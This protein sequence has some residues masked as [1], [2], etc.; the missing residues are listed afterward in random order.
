MK[1]GMHIMKYLNHIHLHQM[2]DYL[3]Q[4]G[5]NN[6]LNKVPEYLITSSGYQNWRKAN[7]PS[8]EEL[9]QQSILSQSMKHRPLFSIL[10]PACNTDLH[11]LKQMAESVLKQSYDHWELCIA[12]GSLKPSK[13]EEFFEDYMQKHVPEAGTS[14]NPE[15]GTSVSPDTTYPGSVLSFPFGSGHIRFTAIDNLG[16]AGNTNAALSLASGDYIVL[17]DHDDLLSPDALYELARA[18]NSDPSVDVLYSDEDMVSNDGTF[19]HNPHFKPDFNPDLLRSCNYITHLYA[20]RRSLALLA[21]GFSGDCDGAQDYDFILKTT[22]KAAKICHIPKVLYHWRIHPGSVAADPNNKSYAYDSAVRA[23]Q[24][25]LVRCDT[26]ARVKRDINPGFY[27]TDYP[28]PG[29][30]LVS[31]FLYH[32]AAPLKRVLMQQRKSRYYTLEFPDSLADANGKYILVLRHAAAISADLIQLL[33]SNCMRSE[34]GIAIPEIRRPDGKTLEAG[35][36][37]NADGE[38]LS[39]FS[40]KDPS[41]PGYHGYAASQRQTSL[42]GPYCFMT[43]IEN[44]RRNWSEREPDNAEQRKQDLYERMT[45]FCFRTRMDRKLITIDPRAYVRL[46]KAGISEAQGIHQIAEQ[47]YLQECPVDPCYTPNFS[48]KNLYRF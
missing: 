2:L 8:P 22:E 46:T 6:L 36:I 37:Y 47:R 13:V 14:V 35:L 43:D 25:H 3:K 33:L 5:L 11:Q 26:H 28:I 42:A 48:Q 40:G 9:K 4:F 15:A 18:I 1:R 41:Y 24:R 20:V 44:L 31:V 27:T 19:F 10:V 32:C 21:G 34:I 17:L 29:F 7:T 39:P 12:D 16:I 38:I 30:P 45:G 23:L